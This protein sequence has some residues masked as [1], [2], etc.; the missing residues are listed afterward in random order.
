MTV[1]AGLKSHSR[2]SWIDANRFYAALGVVMIHCSTDTAGQPF[3]QAPA[4]ERI[5]PALVR[6]IA[7]I[8]GSEL[9]IL[10]S[11]FLIAFKIERR[12]PTYG[13]LVKDQAERLIIPFVAWSIF[14][15]FF[16]LIKAHYFGYEDALFNQ[17]KQ[18]QSWF[19]YFLLGS[20]QFHLHFLPTMFAIFLCYPAMRAASRFPML[21]LVT[22]PLFY[23]MDGV[24]GWIW[25]HIGDAI[26]RD[27][28]VR[29]MKIAG[30]LSYG[31][32]AFALYGIWRRGLTSSESR[33]LLLFLL[34][35]AA[36]LFSAKI[37]YIYDSAMAGQWLVRTGVS[38]YAHLVMPIIVFSAF[39]MTQY[40]GWSAK[41]S[42]LARFTYGI[43]LIH[44]IFIDIFDVTLLNS[45]LIIQ[46]IL[47]VL[48][49]YIIVVPLSFAFAYVLSIIR[50][51][52][53][54]IG[55]GPVPL[56]HARYPTSPIVHA[57]PAREP[58]A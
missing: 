37:I 5:A 1:D 25:G 3:S 29:A 32:A 8:S 43:Y 14:Y 20:A 9:F 41:Y 38:L 49:K 51:L 28:L 2:L 21:A 22:L 24:Q 47:I 18:L 40:G 4:S 52:A 17:L 54:L 11:L 16:R 31:F 10:F 57:P 30:Y 44:P 35:L 53:W 19:G 58:E 12:E 23:V 26:I 7:E 33:M 48:S 27:Y 50:P 15:A 46:P 45:H 6:S 34:T 42:K 55:L 39:M 13:S 36:V 56:I